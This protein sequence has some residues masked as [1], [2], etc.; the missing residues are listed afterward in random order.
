MRPSR[1]LDLGLWLA[2][3][4]PPVVLAVDDGDARRVAAAAVAV[5]LFGA[6]TAV[7]RRWPLA[8]L[9]VPVAVS[10]ALDV[11]MFGPLV[12]TWAALVVFGYLA[13]HR[14]ASARPALWFFATVALAGLPLSALVLR[15]LW[16]WPT[17]LITL[18]LAVVVPWLLGRWR[19]QHAELVRT[20][21][22]LADRLEHEQRAVADRAR[23]RE[24]ARIAGDMHDSLGHDLTLLAVR[25][26]ALELDPGL[27]SRQQAAVRELREAAAAATERLREIIGVL[28]ADDDEGAA[29][30]PREESVETIVER[31][32]DSG[33]P[34]VVEHPDGHM[35]GRPDGHLGDTDG[36]P[37]MTALAVRRVLQEALTNAAK[38]APGA[39]VRVRLTSDDGVV[40]LRVVNDPAPAAA[41][42]GVAS[43]GS[44]LVGLAERVR[45]AGGVLRA[46]P[47]HGG[48]FEV[49]AELPV[50]GVQAAHEH[51]RTTTGLDVPVT[52]A[53]R[54][55]GLAR[56]RVRRRLAQ[57]VGIPV[58]VLTG[59]FVL[60][61]P[62]SFVSSSFSVLDPAAYE[63]L[64]AGE[65]RDDVRSRLPAFTRDGPPDGAPAPPP[66]QDCV[67]YTM[68]SDSARAYRLCFA[69]DRLVSKAVVP[70]P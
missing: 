60:L 9:A 35:D 37:P 39:T 51:V 17:Q 14:M 6:A 58:A 31:A 54:E 70:T 5:P 53:V 21:W 11:Q 57:A 18:L 10:L 68:R 55:L 4:A 34:I 30:P 44:G 15:D 12:W 27:D 16:G 52:T 63:G 47:V 32:R 19:R 24:R 2:V 69:R 65:P 46:G 8:A 67:Y 38:H 33:V 62:L 22:L 42:T 45:L 61:I 36:L 43:G 64:K 7:S 56:R 13:G 40:T 3:C 66:G 25:A 20:G 26:G 49:A 59:I 1:L 28:R 48:G 41:P 50:T 23:L 29:V